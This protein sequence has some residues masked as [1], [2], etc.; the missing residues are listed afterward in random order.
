MIDPTGRHKWIQWSRHDDNGYAQGKQSEIARSV[1]QQS[2]KGQTPAQVW[3]NIKSNKNGEKET[4]QKALQSYLA[5]DAASPKCNRA[6]RVPSI[7]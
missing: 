6:L 2:Y 1:V 5:K 7:C 4:F 3:A